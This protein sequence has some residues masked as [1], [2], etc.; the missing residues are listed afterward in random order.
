MKSVL[1]VG[2]GC[3][4]HTRTPCLPWGILEAPTT[5]SSQFTG[6]LSSQQQAENNFRRLS[7]CLLRIQRSGSPREC[8]RPLT[9]GLAKSYCACAFTSSLS[10]SPKGVGTAM[11]SDSR[12]ARDRRSPLGRALSCDGATGVGCARAARRHIEAVRSHLSGSSESRSEASVRVNL[13]RELQAEI[14]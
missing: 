8:E 13:R 9:R 10:V 11:T 4:S 7:P 14:N 1:N 6:L 12:G 5:R 3:P 2:R